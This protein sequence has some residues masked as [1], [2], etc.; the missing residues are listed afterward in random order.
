[1]T[2]KKAT[3]EENA[4]SKST[5]TN[6]IGVSS[7]TNF[8]CSLRS[9]L[10]MKKT[11]IAITEKMNNFNIQNSPKIFLRLNSIG[12]KFEKNLDILT[13]KLNLLTISAMKNSLGF[14][15]G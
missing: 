14:L 7:L 13:D 1:M 3:T 6:S 10:T 2:K 5:S 11:V 12:D 4:I 9:D 15:D 8:L